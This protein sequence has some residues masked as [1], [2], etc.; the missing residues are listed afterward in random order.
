MSN[1]RP[2]KKPIANGIKLHNESVILTAMLVIKKPI[3]IKS[4][5]MPDMVQKGFLS[6]SDTLS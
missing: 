1:A 4:T 5:P 2:T 6:V 3:P